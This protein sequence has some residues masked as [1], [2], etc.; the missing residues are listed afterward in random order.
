MKYLSLFSGIGGL[1]YGLHKAGNECIGISD[2]KE[3][4][5]QIYQKNMGSVKNWG[6]ITLIN[7]KELPDFDILTGGF[8]CQTFSLAGARRGFEDRK[9]KMIFYIYDILTEKKPKYLVLENVKG[10]TNHNGGRTIK[11]VVQLLQSA[12]YYVRV[13]LLNA[14]FYGSAQNRE[15]VIF[16]G[17]R[18]DFIRKVPEIKNKQVRFKDIRQKNGQFKVISH[19]EFNDQKIQQKR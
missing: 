14:I 2:I 15:R 17:C 16:L 5:I 19:T 8:P 4:S 3:S 1:D 18:E 12:G 7:P 6:D 10:I 13:L 11:N 9:G